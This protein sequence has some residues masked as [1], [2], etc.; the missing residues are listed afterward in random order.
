VQ[1]FNIPS[2]LAAVFLFAS[3]RYPELERVT[4][5]LC[6]FWLPLELDG[7]IEQLGLAVQRVFRLKIGRFDRGNINGINLV[8]SRAARKQTSLSM[9]SVQ[10]EELSGLSVTHERLITPQASVS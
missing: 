2:A 5:S 10:R 6:A 3:I 7:R 9:C 8:L 4:T 1:V